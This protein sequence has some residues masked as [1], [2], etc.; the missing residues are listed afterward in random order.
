MEPIFER[1]DHS[2]YQ[3]GGHFYRKPVDL[4]RTTVV[5]YNDSMDD[6]VKEILNEKKGRIMKFISTLFFALMATSV[7]AAP[8][9][10]SRSHHSGHSQGVHQPIIV[11]PYNY[12]SRR[13]SCTNYT[14]PQKPSWTRGYRIPSFNSRVTRGTG[15]AY[16]GYV[17]PLEYL[18]PFVKEKEYKMVPVPVSPELKDRLKRTQAERKKSLQRVTDFPIKF[19]NEK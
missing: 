5:K 7:L 4:T 6:L 3:A 11:V 19:E 13:R 17:E 1:E 12:G 2:L 10:T 16:Q 9:W 8:N 14:R 15:V 18:N